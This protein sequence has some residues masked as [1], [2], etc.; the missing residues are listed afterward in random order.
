MK[1]P[2]LE[3]T[4]KP[5][6]ILSKEYEAEKGTETV[7]ETFSQQDVF[8]LKIRLSARTS[9]KESLPYH[10][11]FLCTYESFTHKE[12]FNDSRLSNHFKVTDRTWD[13]SLMN[14]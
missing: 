4:V 3:T 2:N 14:L 9:E 5:I 11:Y 10:K 8:L 6:C 12:G 7:L 1:Y 13:I